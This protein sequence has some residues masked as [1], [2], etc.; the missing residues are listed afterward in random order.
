MQRA[1]AQLE[2]AAADG[3]AARV[4]VRGGEREDAGARLDEAGDAGVA[5]A[6][7]RGDRQVGGGQAAVGDVDRHRTDRGDVAAGAGDH[8]GR[9]A[10]AVGSER[11][12]VP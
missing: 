10:R 5:V 7:D 3:R 2:R 6:N 4:D 12:K 8:V 11:G 9:V 1:V